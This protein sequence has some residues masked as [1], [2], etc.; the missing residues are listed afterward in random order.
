MVSYRRRVFNVNPSSTERLRQVWCVHRSVTSWAAVTTADTLTATR[1]CVESLKHKLPAAVHG[2]AAFS[3]RYLRRWPAVLET[4]KNKNHETSAAARSRWY[5]TEWIR[6]QAADCRR[7]WQ[8]LVASLCSLAVQSKL[9]RHVQTGLQT[10]RAE[11]HSALHW[12]S[13]TDC[14]SSRKEAPLERDSGQFS[15]AL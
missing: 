8:H 15:D 9:C 1:W 13:G 11:L 4:N 6:P 7:R 12:N 2:T 10:L 14:T 5:E 3:S